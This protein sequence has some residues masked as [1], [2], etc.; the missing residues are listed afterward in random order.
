M[1]EWINKKLSTISV[2]SKALFEE[3][4][5]AYRVK[6][7]R[8][9]LLFS[10]LG[11]LTII[12]EVIISSKKPE[13]IEQTRWD[14]ITTDLV[15][16]DKWESTV[17]AALINSSNPI[18]NI[19]ESLRQQIKY[20]K[21]R[22]NDCAHFKENEINNSHVEIFWSFIR[23]NLNK[24]TI[25]GGKQNLLKKF[26]IHFDETKTPPEKSYIF[27]IKQI[28][29]SIEVS[30]GISFFE[31]LDKIIEEEN[32]WDGEKINEIYYNLIVHIENP[33]M[34]ARLIRFIKS[35]RNF[36]LHLIAEYPQIISDLLYSPEDIRMIWKKRMYSN[37]GS[38]QHSIFAVLLRTNLIPEKELDEALNNYYEKFNQEGFNNIPKNKEVRKELA[39]K[40]ILGKVYSDYFERIQIASMKFQEINRKADLITLLFEFGNIDENMVKGICDMYINSTNPWWLTKSLY[41]LLQDYPAKKEEFEKICTK[42][43][44]NFPDELED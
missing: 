34:K 2:D 36:D 21:D 22:R 17:Y 27:L 5:L 37:L 11:F 18:F 38:L 43:K 10:Y 23:S 40:S 32:P 25:E 13:N 39:G 26:A 16:E 12:K 24:I 14:K 1:E 6:A 31:E 44:L 42:L 28:E 8:A 30:E 29:S 3:S 41:E 20:W 35:H 19:N 4:I 9:A 7:N 15:H 33:Q